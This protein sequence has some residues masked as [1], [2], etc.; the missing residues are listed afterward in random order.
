MKRKHVL[1]GMASFKLESPR[2]LFTKAV[3]VASPSLLD[4]ED[5]PRA[6]GQQPLHIF[7]LEL[8]ADLSVHK[9]NRSQVFGPK[10]G[11]FN[12]HS[13]YGGLGYH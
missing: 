11:I 3:S 9:L 4:F 5:W 2:P 12:Y 1:S 7:N 13:L 6:P 10:A 8:Q